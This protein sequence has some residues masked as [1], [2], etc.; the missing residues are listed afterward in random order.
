[1]EDSV[2]TAQNSDVLSEEYAAP[3]G[4]MWTVV[5][6]NVIKDVLELENGWFRG[7]A[8]HRDQIARLRPVQSVREPWCRSHRFV[9]TGYLATALYQIAEDEF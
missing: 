6:L 2:E 7:P 1:M 3:D 8:D 9:K 4:D 5:T